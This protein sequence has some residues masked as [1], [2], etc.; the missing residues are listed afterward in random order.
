MQKSWTCTVEELGQAVSGQVITRGKGVFQRVGTDTRE[1]LNGKLFVA[2]K[3]D[4][5]DA[6]DFV[7][8]AINAGASAVLV[9]SLKAEWKEFAEKVA[10]IKVA[11]TLT[12]L[13]AFARHWRK[14]HAFKVIGITGSNGKTSTKEFTYALLKNHFAC[15]KPKG[16][17]N[18]HWGVPL[19]ILDAGPEQTHLI[20]EMGMSKSG[21]LWR[22]CQLA[23]PDIVVCTTVG[24][25]H[26]GELGSQENVA[27]AKEEIYVACPKA[28]H[29]FNMDNEW[30]MRMQTRSQ[31]TQIKFSSFKPDF[32]IHLRAQ[33]MTWDGLDILGHIKKTEGQTWVKILGRHNVVNLMA[34]SGL[35]LACGLQ[36]QQIWE[37]LGQIHENAWGRNQMVPLNNGARVL[38]DAYNAN[39]DS[40]LALV[41]NIYE[42]EVKGRKFLVLGDMKQQGAFAKQVHE[43]TGERAAGIQAE[44]VWFVGEHAA[45][46][47][48]GYEKVRKPAH[49]FSSPKVDQDTAA[50]FLSLLKEGDLVA[51]KGSRGMELEHVLDKWPLKS[52]LGPKTT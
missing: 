13:Q 21:E 18:N 12:G 24:R 47:W 10:F 4:R 34:S 32:D 39:P 41:K 15:H 6:H 38:F 40:V 8:Q 37:G 23:E 42:M 44:G 28:V 11:D 43:E 5:F 36:P 3:G 45:D 52:P 20:L 1:D 25:A 48:R 35:A 29:V 7:P 9:H 2:L 26:T 14:K 49:K 19:T 30:T 17:F 31:S 16:S 27:K 46:F 50:Q 33:R 22:L 51:I